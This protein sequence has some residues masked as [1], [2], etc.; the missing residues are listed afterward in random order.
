MK[1]RPVSLESMVERARQNYNKRHPFYEIP[2]PQTEA[3]QKLFKEVQRQTMWEDVIKSVARKM[4]W[5]KLV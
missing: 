2:A 4:K 5:K 1:I 3:G